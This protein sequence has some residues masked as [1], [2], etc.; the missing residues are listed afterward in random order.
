MRIPPLPKKKIPGAAATAP[1]IETQTKRV[2]IDS[3][4]KP[5]ILKIHAILCDLI[6]GI[7]AALFAIA[8]LNL[9][10]VLHV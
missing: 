1:G 5:G 2:C 10:G 3:C 7:A 9:V 8:L 6:N 4:T